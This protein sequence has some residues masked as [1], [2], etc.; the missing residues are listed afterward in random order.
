MNNLNAGLAPLA[1]K[2]TTMSHEILINN[3]TNNLLLPRIGGEAL[4]EGVTDWPLSPNGLPLTLVASIPNSFIAKHTGFELP[5]D[6]YTSVFSY[7]SD[8]DYFLDQITYHGDPDELSYLM[9]GSTKV[10]QHRI[11]GNISK[12][13]FIP[14]HLMEI[15]SFTSNDKDCGSRIGGNPCLLQNET[16]QTEEFIFALQ[17]RSSDF[18]S[19]F[20]D[21]FGIPDAL[22]Y[23]F[24]RENPQ[25]SD[26]CGLFFV[27]TT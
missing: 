26:R 12:G 20:N 24:L 5:E 10:I 19:K 15:G 27:Q 11:G 25:V 21:I 8:S 7:Y 18:P 1:Y 6:H 14:S 3:P 22:G 23:L 17:L 16:I 2:G 9:Q 4:I 13:T